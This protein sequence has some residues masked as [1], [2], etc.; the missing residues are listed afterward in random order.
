LKSITHPAV[1]NHDYCS[2]DSTGYFNYFGT[3][4]G[5]PG[6][7]WYSYNIG[8]WH[9]IALNSNCGKVGGCK[10][11]SAQERWLRADLA[12]NPTACTL[13]YWHHPRWSSGSAGSNPIT[14]GLYTALY[15]AGADIVLSGHDHFYERFAPMDPNG[16]L[17]LQAGVRQ[18]IVG[19]GGKSKDSPGNAAAN[20]EIRSSTY[21]VLQLT[22]H[23]NSYDWEFEAIPGEGFVDTGSDTCS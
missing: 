23:S 6:Q 1:G 21:G 22:L 7:G 3:A 2:G 8:S 10:P 19:T 14:S 11:G 9:L 18:F 17:D 15:E 13:A 12:A 20:S 5:N 4:A 16:S